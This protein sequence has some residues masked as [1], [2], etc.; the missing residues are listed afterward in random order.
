MPDEYV[1]RRPLLQLL[2]CLEFAEGHP[3]AEHLALTDGVCADLG[4]PRLQFK[5]ER[6]YQAAQADSVNGSS[7]C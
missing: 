2:W 6:D 1:L 7:C 5:S 4:M 3:S